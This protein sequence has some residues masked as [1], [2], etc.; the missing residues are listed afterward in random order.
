M[1]P[2]IYKAVHMTSRDTIIDITSRNQHQ[3]DVSNCAPIFKFL[4]QKF[5]ITN[6]G[7]SF[8]EMLISA[9]GDLL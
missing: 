5:S 4:F 3:K 1:L 6:K 7:L 2:T 9:L 8:I